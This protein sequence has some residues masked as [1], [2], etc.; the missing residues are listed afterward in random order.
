VSAIGLATTLWLAAGADTVLVLRSSGDPDRALLE[1]RIAAELSASGFHVLSLTAGFEEAHDVPGLLWSRCK[2]EG[3]RA[4]LWIALRGDGS[5]DAWA[6]EPDAAKAVVRTWPAPQT[7]NERATVALKVA[8]L[9]HAML[10]E[11]GAVE[12]DDPDIPSGN[13]RFRLR[14]KPFWTFGT[15][16]GVIVTPGSLQPEAM[17][18]L[19]LGYEVHRN[20]SIELQAAF[21]VAPERTETEES[22]L[23][24]L[25]VMGQWT[26]RHFGPFAIGLVGTTGGLMLWTSLDYAPRGNLAW[27]LAAGVS[28]QLELIERVRLQLLGVGGIALP[29]LIDQGS[30]APTQ[31]TYDSVQPVFETLLR[32]QFE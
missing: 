16:L 12:P 13:V 5:I 32:L 25:R 4:A 15:G 31:A 7:F 9:L 19:H 30:K 26:P 17:L 28:A 20:F 18:E 11:A 29:K 8:E 2:Q 22:G 14:F 27:L 23:A 21:T 24:Y 6:A 3:A 1:E 10:L